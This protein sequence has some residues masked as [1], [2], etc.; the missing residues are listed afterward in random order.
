MLN[1]A[2][3]QRHYLVTDSISKSVAL[4]QV[5]SSTGKN[6]HKNIFPQKQYVYRKY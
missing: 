4:Q 1:K 2:C 6:V 3:E 5:A